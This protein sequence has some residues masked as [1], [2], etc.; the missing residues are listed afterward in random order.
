MKKDREHIPYCQLRS[1]HVP[2]DEHKQPKAKCTCFVKKETVNVRI[3]N[4]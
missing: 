2:I 1:Y 4:Y 3:K